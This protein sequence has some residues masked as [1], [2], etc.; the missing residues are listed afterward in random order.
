MNTRTAKLGV[1]GL[2]DRQVLSATLINGDL[3]ISQSNGNDTAVV[4]QV[5]GPLG[6]QFIRVQETISGVTLSPKSFF[7]PFVK[8][9]TYNGFAGDDRFDN[10]TSV[11]SAAFGGLGNDYLAGGHNDDV[12]VG[13]DGDDEIHGR[14]GNDYL[15]GNAGNDLLRAGQGNDFLFGGAG[16]DDLFGALG[17]DYLD[18]GKDGVAD[19]VRGGPGADTFV[20]ERVFRFPFSFNRDYPQDFSLAEGDRI[21]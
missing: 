5:S 3:V 14:E 18:G 20:A 6:L 21:I 17:N 19:I 9:I 11:K 13:G 16:K 4:T 7:A 1:E 10:Q 15:Y 2:E 8:H 12:L